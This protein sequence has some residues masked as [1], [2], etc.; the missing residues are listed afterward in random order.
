MMAHGRSWSLVVGLFAVAVLPLW[1]VACSSGGEDVGTTGQRPARSAL[2]AQET[3][4]PSSAMA[5]SPPA[6]DGTVSSSTADGVSTITF[7]HTT[8]TGTDRL[9]LV[10]ISANS[11]SAARTINS[12][13]FTPS[14]G[15]AT[16]LTA[17]GSVENGAGRLAAIYLLL[18]PPS[19]V[20]G[21]VAV[22]F[23]GSVGNGI[24]AGA[25]NFQGVDQAEPLDEFASAT[26]SSTTT[27]S[28]SVP[29]DDGDLVFA[30]TFLGAATPPAVT[31]GSGQSLLWDSSVDRAR[32]TSSTKQASASATTVSW[33]SGANGYWAVGGVSINPVAGGGPTPDAGTPVT[34]DAGTPIPPAH[35]P[36]VAGEGLDRATSPVVAGVCNQ[37]SGCCDQ[38]WS[39]TCV[40]R[41]TLLARQMGVSPDL[42]GRD[43]WMMGPVPGTAQF[44]PR[45]FSIVALGDPQD[46]NYAAD[47]YGTQDVEGP[48]AAR[49]TIKLQSFDLNWG[50]RQ[51]VAA[52]ARAGLDLKWGTMHGQGYYGDA[53]K[54]N[55][56]GVT[57]DQIHTQFPTRS[58][59]ATA[60]PAW[61][62]DRIDFVD[63]AT[64]LRALSATIDTF[65]AGMSRSSPNYGANTNGII[66]M[67]GSDPQM[68]VFWTEASQLTGAYEIRVNAP[69]GSI[70]I[71]NVTG[72]NPAIFAAG[73]VMRFRA[74][75]ILWNFPNA[76]SL[77][78]RST[79][80]RGS[81]LAPYAEA[82]LLWGQI[83]GSVVVKKAVRIW[84][85]LHSAPFNGFGIRGCLSAD[86]YWSCSSDTYVDPAT[87]YAVFPASEAGFLHIP[88]GDYQAWNTS[89]TLVTRHSPDHRI[90]YSFH[91]ASESP[92]NK[93]LAVFFNGGPGFTTAGDLYAFNTGPYTLD[94]D[95][96]GSAD[97]AS[98]EANTWQEFANLL[99]IDAPATGF[100]YPSNSEPNKKDIGI[101]M[102][103][104][105]GIFL[106]VISR[107]LT[108]H[109]AIVANPVVLVGESYGGTRATFMSKW[110][111]D[112]SLLSQAYSSYRD[113]QLLGDLEAYFRGAFSSSNPGA[114]RIVTKF[115]QQILI[116]PVVVG[117]IQDGLNASMNPIF[118]GA[119]SCPSTCIADR[120]CDKYDC[121]KPIVGSDEWLFH[122]VYDVADKLT[123][124][125]SSL[126]QVF[127][128]DPRTIR[129]MF[130][131]ERGFA[132][133]RGGCTAPNCP[134]AGEMSDYFGTLDSSE[135]AY[136]WVQNGRV[137]T[138]YGAGTT[139]QARTWSTPGAG[140]ICG[141]AFRDNLLRGVAAFITYA[142]YDGVVYPP[143]IANAINDTPAF[144]TYAHYDASAAND[145]GDSSRPGRIALFVPPDTS[146][147]VTTPR[148][149]SGHSVPMHEAPSPGPAHQ[150]RED[151][152]RWISNTRR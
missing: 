144:G 119:T 11:Y 117:E 75:N 7:P 135:D 48:L 124:H 96:V 129:W 150:L 60:S 63:A 91:P 101:D 44:Y 46:Q 149:F 98:N 72:T 20:S 125:L 88:G 100:S 22:N 68:N 146:L 6:L 103:R 8:G 61:S 121:D 23:S 38:R 104:D 127:G 87:G 152:R 45:D 139:E 128:V 1:L 134:V 53:S 78:I 133:G 5:S 123:R 113:S 4:I 33:T 145:I 116:Q 94:P 141:A 132:H 17:V 40:E 90:W 99:Y 15:S 89:N 32:G 130:K 3:A 108:R 85:E 55:F 84:T 70:V 30:T 42:C 80:L 114:S 142:E 93:P 105:A 58:F 115:G 35:S 112:Y 97:Y 26:A 151:A 62:T 136:F 82:D 67:T 43:T 95:I 47:I 24:V 9:L 137:N 83:A 50:G 66:T 140:H 34:P 122:Q 57:F 71:V 106:S 21:T 86:P 41:A 102:D 10:G 79:Y 131:S 29:S 65:T 2:K 39:L 25:A 56:Q 54:N 14:G 81:I 13:T 77:S 52:I 120:T 27:I 12:V 143:S 138:V 148:Y 126:Q 51:P 69:E 147:H 118:Q 74:E 37:D 107:F 36:C 59:E 64:K 73:F 76:T 49:G 110:I 18:N 92:Q 31:Q 111:L 109:P 19:G 16:S 28:L